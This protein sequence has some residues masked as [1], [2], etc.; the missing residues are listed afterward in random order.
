M[1]LKTEEMLLGHCNDRIS[2]SFMEVP[3]ENETGTNAHEKEIK[4]DGWERE[5]RTYTN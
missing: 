4:D 1:T 3:H 5:K 2:D